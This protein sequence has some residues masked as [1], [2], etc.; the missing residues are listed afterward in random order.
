MFPAIQFLLVLIILLIYIHRLRAK[1]DIL[2][3]FFENFHINIRKNLILISI[4]AFIFY[5]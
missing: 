2:I 3:Y 4:L 5:N 1:N